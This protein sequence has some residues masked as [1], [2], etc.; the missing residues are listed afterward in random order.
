MIY[1]GWFA[2]EGSASAPYMTVGYQ[3]VEQD[4]AD[5][6]AIPGV[7]SVVVVIDGRMNLCA[8]FTQ[9]KMDSDP[10]PCTTCPC[11]CG[12][13]P[14]FDSITNAS[15]NTVALGITEKFCQSEHVGG[16]HI[17]LE[18]LGITKYH[19]SVVSFLTS[20]AA[21][22]A[23][24]DCKSTAFPTGRSLSVFGFAEDLSSDILDA[25][26][27]NGMVIISGYDLYPDLNSAGQDDFQFNSI[28]EYKNKLSRQLNATQLALKNH[29]TSFS[30]AI[31]ISASSH[32]YESY[33]P[34]KLYCGPACTGMSNT[35]TMSDYINAAYDVMSYPEHSEFLAM[36]DGTAKDPTPSQFRGST[37]W[38]MSGPQ[39]PNWEYPKHSGNMWSPT[40][41][42]ADAYK[43]LM[44][45]LK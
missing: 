7:D 20:M 19:G 21:G 34:S 14:T 39:T 33:T 31:P 38:L 12:E 43:T 30:L 9:F 26:G 45:R 6:S 10:C 28:V 13:S 18:P 41:P 17:D 1:G 4:Y 36:H 44:E 37:L 2:R 5:Y 29:K 40:H 23:A 22:L 16:V 35:V 32:E 27:P 8:E 42:N 11:P 25:L 3:V 24:T 15:L